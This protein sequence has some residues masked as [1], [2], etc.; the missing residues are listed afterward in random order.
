VQ[1]NR[2]TSA[3]YRFA[4]CFALAT[5]TIYAA[6]AAF[7]AAGA[8]GNFKDGNSDIAWSFL[9]VTLLALFLL[10]RNIVKWDHLKKT[11]RQ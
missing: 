2:P 6:G 4:F 3:Q 8:Y 11:L 9:S 7:T 5:R 1:D 10:Y